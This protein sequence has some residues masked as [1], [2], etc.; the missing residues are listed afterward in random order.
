[1]GT[2]K[3]ATRVNMLLKTFGAPPT[4]I[5][6]DYRGLKILVKRGFTV[7]DLSTLFLISRPT[8]YKVLDKEPVLKHP[9]ITLY[10]NA[11]IAE[12][13]ESTAV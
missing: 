2:Y 12:L 8:V 7:T 3:P 5:K 10:I 6:L 11:R 9:G 13:L 4:D 1:M